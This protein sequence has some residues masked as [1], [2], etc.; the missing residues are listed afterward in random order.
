M[1]AETAPARHACAAAL[2]L[3]WQRQSARDAAGSGGALIEGRVR[4]I[5]PLPRSV[6]AQRRSAAS[7]EPRQHRR[8]NAGRVAE[9]FK[10]AVLKTARGASL[11]WVRIPPLPP[12]AIRY[13]WIIVD[14]ANLT[15][16]LPTR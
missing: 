7:T 14:L 3:R 6:A 12:T 4:V 10:A 11:S 8:D 15:I 9:W 2:R 16:D 5:R 1:Q 13:F